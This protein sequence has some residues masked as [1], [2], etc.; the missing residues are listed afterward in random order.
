MLN[1][2]NIII[3]ICFFIFFHFIL[4]FFNID[5]FEIFNYFEKNQKITSTEDTQEINNTILELESSIQELK[6]INI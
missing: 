5:F 4:Y 3:F 2:K 1:L 6:D